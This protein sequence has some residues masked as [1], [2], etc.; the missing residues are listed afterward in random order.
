[1]RVRAALGALLC[2]S[3]VMPASA[4]AAPPRRE[5]AKPYFDS[6]AAARTQAAQSAGGTVAAARP[7]KATSRARA[8]LR[9]KLGR[10]GVLKIDPLTGTP[11]QLMRT[12]GALS[13]PR[14]GDR[15]DIARDFVRANRV[16]LGLDE[17]DLGGLQASRR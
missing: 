15:A 11:R 5:D 17:A 3:A 6:R 4:S 2:A 16:A 14:A 10:E 12:D 9:G 8:T 7:S 1:M 13:A